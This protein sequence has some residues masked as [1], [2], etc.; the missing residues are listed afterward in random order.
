MFVWAHDIPEYVKVPA[1]AIRS[2]VC[3]MDL[4]PYSINQ[5][6]KGKEM[7]AAC[8][9]ACGGKDTF[10]Q[11]VNRR[12]TDFEANHAY[13]THVLAIGGYA[14]DHV[15]AYINAPDVGSRLTYVG[16]V[17][18]PSCLVHPYWLVTD[19]DAY[20]ESDIA[21]HKF[22]SVVAPETMADIAENDFKY[23]R[24]ILEGNRTGIE[25]MKALKEARDARQRKPQ[26]GAK[27][28]NQS[29]AASTHF[30]SHTEGASAAR[31]RAATREPPAAPTFASHTE[32]ASA[33][34][35]RAAP[36][37][38][39]TTPTFASHTEGASAAKAEVA[40]GSR[41]QRPT[42]ASHTEGA[43]AASR[44]LRQGSRRA[45]TDFASHTEGQASP[46]EGCAKGALGTDDFCSAHGGG[47]R[48]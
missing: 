38:P 2:A 44:G 30:A 40:Q 9:R 25:R 21:M 16:A 10:Q 24:D 33:A 8:K 43:S 1:T 6:D 35:P 22:L 11:V 23:F 3:V 20:P 37:E 13:A 14:R 36:R 47:E 17:M 27:A 29:H 7:H 34:R 26:C 19:V 31:P 42:F 46:A 45:K 41:R 5:S 4:H 18:H 32:G 28:T 12:L 48:C 39:P 15:T